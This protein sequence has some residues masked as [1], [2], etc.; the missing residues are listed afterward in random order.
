MGAPARKAYNHVL[1]TQRD[2]G[3]S[4]THSAT[5]RVRDRL[6]RIAKRPQKA[7]GISIKTDEDRV[8]NPVLD[9]I[10]AIIRTKDEKYPS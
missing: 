3:A 9:R 2:K 4:S 1:Q 10:T 8:S 6:W 7:K 5:Q